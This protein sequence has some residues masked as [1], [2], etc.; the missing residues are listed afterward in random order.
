M[1]YSK[2][3]KQSLQL[4]IPC[5]S[6]HTVWGLCWYYFYQHRHPCFHPDLYLRSAACQLPNT[7]FQSLLCLTMCYLWN[8]SNLFLYL[9]YLDTDIAMC[10][11]ASWVGVGTIFSTRGMFSNGFA[12]GRGGRGWVVTSTLGD[13]GW[14]YQALKGTLAQNGWGW[15]ASMMRNC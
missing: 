11:F 6:A 7:S 14:R 10:S 12:E 3:A 4:F 1:P 15:A 9:L 5:I 13:H 2:E 8:L